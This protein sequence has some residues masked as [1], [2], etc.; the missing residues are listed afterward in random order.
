MLAIRLWVSV[1]VTSRE[2]FRRRRG[3]SAI[4][5]RA[6]QGMVSVAA[7]YRQQANNYD[8]ADGRAVTFT[9]TAGEE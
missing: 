2:G 6:I 8:F 3:M 1:M 4:G 5:V 9:D 7:G